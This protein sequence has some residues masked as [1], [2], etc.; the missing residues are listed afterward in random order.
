M[1]TLD[2]PA[3]VHLPMPTEP[4]APAHGCGVC[5]A[6]AEQ[7]E[8]ACQSGDLSLATDCN[9]EIRNHGGHGR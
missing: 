8:A 4:P 5:T 9:V 3:L 6:L 7:R 2:L 1:T